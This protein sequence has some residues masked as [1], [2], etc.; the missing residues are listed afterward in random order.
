VDLESDIMPEF[1]SFGSALRFYREHI[2][3]RLRRFVP[4]RLPDIQLSAKEVVS[5]MRE[6]DY[7]ISPA[8]YSD[9]EQALYLPKDPENFMEKVVPCLALDKDSLE[10]KN[11]MDHLAFDVLK[12]KLG[13]DIA[14]EYWKV[15]RSARHRHSQS[16]KPR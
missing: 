8:A 7:P 6:A 12:Q 15:I 10:Y 2:A 11:L 3:E 13:A 4:G 14:E 5:C 1:P 9:I 16:V